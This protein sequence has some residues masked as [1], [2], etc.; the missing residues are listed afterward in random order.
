M[1]SIRRE[2]TLKVIRVK[3][4]HLISILTIFIVF[5]LLPPSIIAE[6]IEQPYPLFQ[7]EQD[8]H[9]Q[10]ILQSSLS[11]V[12][13]D[14]E[15]ERIQLKL[16]ELSSTLTATEIEIE[17]QEQQITDKRDAAGKV[18]RAYYMGERNDIFWSLLKV[19]SIE[20]FFLV[21]DFLEIIMKQDR[22]TL[23]AYK[24]QYDILQEHYDAYQQEETKLIAM[25]NDLK[26]QRARVLALENQVEQQLEGRSDA[27]RIRILIQQLQ[28]FWE[29]KGIEEVNKY[30]RALALSMNE[31]PGW[32]QKNEQYISM[33]G[34]KYTISLPDDA[35][36]SF[37]REQNSMFNDFEFIFENNQI[38]ARGQRDDISIEIQGK[39]SIVNEP[40]NYIQF[41]MDSLY[42][43][44]FLLPDTTQQELA[45]QFD[46]NFYP[47]YIL[48]LLRAKSV[49]ISDGQLSI[50]L[51]LAI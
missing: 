34:F 28:S 31:L 44:G 9:I 16:N 45:A 48:S 10:D 21:V 1:K 41:T 5:A 49:D 19:D 13:I 40:S 6:P 2:E 12:E 38:I 47:S 35:L 26:Q 3:P 36:N 18:L 7:S 8:D 50:E 42:F 46:L 22:N 15:I 23:T 33:K 37:L 29:N 24:E 27:D 32:L 14:K 20:S 25:E 51:Q 39:Y 17:Q 4:R 43:N 30:F 11:I